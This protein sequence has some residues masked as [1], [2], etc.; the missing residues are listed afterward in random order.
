MY[1]NIVFCNYLLI[2]FYNFYLLINKYVHLCINIFSISISQENGET[3]CLICINVPYAST[4]G[5]ELPEFKYNISRSRKA[6]LISAPLDDASRSERARRVRAERKERWD[7]IK[8]AR[9]RTMKRV[10]RS[11]ELLDPCYGNL[12]RH[13]PTLVRRTLCRLWAPREAA[14]CLLHSTTHCL[15]RNNHKSSRNAQPLTSTSYQKLSPC[16]GKYPTP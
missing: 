13:R 2:S 15:Q 6:C 7:A 11:N 10:S 8:Q 12:R 3:R 16:R 9:T 1:Y 14:V 4:K 5:L